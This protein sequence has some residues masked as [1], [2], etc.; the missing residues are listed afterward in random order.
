VQRMAAI[1]RL[2][3]RPPATPDEARVMLGLPLRRG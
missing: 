3:E 2:A 1:G